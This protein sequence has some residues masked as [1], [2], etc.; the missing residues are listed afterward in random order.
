M[1]KISACFY[2]YGNDAIEGNT[3]VMQEREET[4]ES[5]DAFL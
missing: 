5:F 1:S 4:E 3:L 2:A